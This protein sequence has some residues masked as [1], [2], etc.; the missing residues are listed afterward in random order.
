M[1]ASYRSPFVVALAGAAAALALGGCVISTE[2]DPALAKQARMRQSHTGT[3]IA[4]HDVRDLPGEGIRAMSREE[5]EKMKNTGG[6]R[7]AM[8]P[9]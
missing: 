7:G 6:N 4:R 9:Q 3:N 2:F 8:V 1:K 5:V